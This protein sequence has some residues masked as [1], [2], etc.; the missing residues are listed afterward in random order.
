[1]R[2]QTKHAIKTYF[3]R[4]KTVYKISIKNLSMNNYI[5]QLKQQ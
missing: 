5:D 4:I 2:L 3:A 1:M